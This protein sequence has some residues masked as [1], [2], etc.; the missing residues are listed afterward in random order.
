MPSSRA[1]YDKIAKDYNGHMTKLDEQIRDQVSALFNHNIPRGNIM[2]FGG[3]T[4]LDL[5]WLLCDNYKV[6]FLEPAANMRRIAKNSIFDD[7]GNLV[8]AEEHTDFHDWSANHLPFDEKMNG[9][10]ANFAVFN[11]IP[12]ID[13]LFEKLALICLDRCYIQATVLDTHPIKMLNGYSM[14]TAVKSLLN[15]KIKSQNS[16]D[17]I[18]QE[19]YLHTIQQYK[20]AAEKYFDIISYRSIYSSAFAS[21]ILYK[22]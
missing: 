3:G 17:G 22:K 8:F 19:T 11:C 15:K 21:L 7:T 6:H 18:T 16:Y 20:S 2:D 9:I 4:G 10:L 12:D 1:Y 13:C 5:P 14:N